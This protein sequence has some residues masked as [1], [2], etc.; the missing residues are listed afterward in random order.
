MKQT[1][2]KNP[3]GRNKIQVNVAQSK[4][5]RLGVYHF[6]FQVLAEELGITGSDIDEKAESVIDE[7]DRVSDQVYVTRNDEIV[8]SIRLF[9]GKDKIPRE[10]TE[11]YGLKTFAEFDSK[12]LS[13]T[14]RLTVDARLRR[15]NSKVPALISSTAFKMALKN[16]ALFD[17]THCTPEL[18]VL[19]E[20]LGYRRYTD[21]FSHPDLGLQVPLVMVLHDVEHLIR[22]KS[23]FADI[24]RNIDA[25]KESVHWFHRTFPDAA[26]SVGAK[27]DDEQKF[28][29][30]LTKQMHQSPL[31]GIPLFEGMSFREAQQFLR[32]ASVI[33]YKSQQSLTR[34][35]EKGREMFVILSGSVEVKAPRSDAI[36][37][38]LNRGAL[39]GE[40]AFLSETPRSADITV[41][42]EAEVL[43]LNQDVFNDVVE[44]I[45]QVAA[46][47]LFN[48]SLILCERLKD[49]SALVSKTKSVKILQ[50]S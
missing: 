35:G 30:F 26:I 40:L 22:T 13:F 31:H 34:A 25:P 15:A 23:P 28:W 10:F 29:E 7:H 41:V 46:K 45:P 18:V 8:A 33:Q 4:E 2:G 19:Y 16:G 5:D 32:S 11:N 43:V 9:S 21:N 49:T 48:L 12:A 27:A 24:V 6:R 36:L 39:V 17:F 47:V 3:G 1:V 37:A 38:E 20:R 50:D 44:T 42:D 14:G